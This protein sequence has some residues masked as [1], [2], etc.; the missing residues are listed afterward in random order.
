VVGLALVVAACSSG[1]G[2]NGTR[3]R[4][5]TTSTTVAASTSSTSST[6]VAPGATSALAPILTRAVEEER[7]AKATYDNVI[8]RLGSIQPFV[9]I[10]ASEQQHID[11]LLGLTAKYAVDVSSVRPAGDPSP[12][13]KDAAC[14]L[15]VDAEKAD[16]ALYDE[17]LPQVS[18]YADVTRVLQSLRA[19]SQDNHLPAFERCA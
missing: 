12:A 2:G 6:T 13:T 9:N 16:V 17:L 5:R 4:S 14:R 19:A 3:A 15:G 18:A 7:H 8:G 11:A 1:D 10:A